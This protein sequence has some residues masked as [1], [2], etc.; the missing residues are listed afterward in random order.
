MVEIISVQDTKCSQSLKLTMELYLNCNSDFSIE[1]EAGK[2]Y[3]V[4]EAFEL[5]GGHKLA[6]WNISFGRLIQHNFDLQATKDFYA[7]I[8]KIEAQHS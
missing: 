6:D 2:K 1:D 5:W 7:N 4:D 3:T 8:A